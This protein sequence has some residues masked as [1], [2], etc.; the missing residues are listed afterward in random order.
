MVLHLDFSLVLFSST[1]F[2]FSHYPL[3]E[4]MTEHAKIWQALA[5]PP[6]MQ[7]NNVIIIVNE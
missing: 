4:F 5:K 1:P 7:S 2:F 3:N 6:H